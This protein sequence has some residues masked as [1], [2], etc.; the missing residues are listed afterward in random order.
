[1]TVDTGFTNGEATI[2]AF[3][4]VNLSLG[5]QPLA[6]QFQ[7]I[8][9][10]LR[11]IEAERVGC[12]CLREILKLLNTFPAILYLSTL[13]YICACKLV[14]TSHNIVDGTF[15]GVNGDDFGITGK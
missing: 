5:D 15:K 2:K 9:L 13:V 11:M 10:D 3:I 4:S 7:E 1:M 12:M 8:P 6:A 14:Y